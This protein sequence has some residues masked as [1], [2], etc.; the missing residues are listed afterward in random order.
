MRGSG[1]A[2]GSTTS[3]RSLGIQPGVGVDYPLAH[4]WAA[5]AELDFRVILSP[6]DTSGTSQYRFVAALVYRASR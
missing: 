2:F 1:S 6:P 3:S 4:A 5:R